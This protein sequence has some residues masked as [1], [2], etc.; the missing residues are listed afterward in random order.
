MSDDLKFKCEECGKEFDPDPDTMMETHWCAV[1]E[2]AF[3]EPENTHAA[4]AVV[5][6][7][8][9]DDELKM[10]GLD[11]EAAQKILA[12]EEVVAG[13]MCICRECQDRLLKEQHP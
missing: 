6:E 13:A 10:A 8:A 3:G 12:G 9:T 7:E 11:R 5:L 1:Y 4:D 2:P